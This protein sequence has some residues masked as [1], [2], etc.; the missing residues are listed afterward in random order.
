MNPERFAQNLAAVTTWW[1]AQPPETR[2][3]CY[4]PQEIQRATHVP[5][6]HLPAVLALLGWHR[7]SHW[8]RENGRRV[9]RV[10]Y[11][12]PGHRVPKPLRGRPPLDVL[13]FYFTNLTNY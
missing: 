7:A 10:R 13:A 9:R 1:A 6:A 8:T 12:P 3:T 4:R 11:A 5:Q 2:R